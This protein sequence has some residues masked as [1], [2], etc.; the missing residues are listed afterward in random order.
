MRG[1]CN[2]ALEQG[3]RKTLSV[4]FLTLFLGLPLNPELG[5]Q[6]ATVALLPLPYSTSTH[7]WGYRMHCHAWL[8]MWV[9]G[10]SNSYLQACMVSTLTH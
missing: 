9:V 10:N 1:A 5:G 6:Q 3:Q 2:S 7:H 8:F 4:L